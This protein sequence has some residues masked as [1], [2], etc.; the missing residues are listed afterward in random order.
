MNRVIRSEKKD[1]QYECADFIATPTSEMQVRVA[2]DKAWQHIRGGLGEATRE[3]TDKDASLNGTVRD[4]LEL[5]L[6]VG[7]VLSAPFTCHWKA[8]EG[9][10]S[11]LGEQERPVVLDQQE[12][13]GERMAWPSRDLEQR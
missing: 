2:S 8:A 6:S 9:V 7:G 12:V 13:G 11:Q 1:G 4:D 3:V 5:N 10:C